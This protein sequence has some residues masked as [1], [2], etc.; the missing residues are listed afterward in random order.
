MH[1]GYFSENAELKLSGKVCQICASERMILASGCQSLVCLG[2]TA[3]LSE[4]AD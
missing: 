4:S 2:M 3:A 1:E